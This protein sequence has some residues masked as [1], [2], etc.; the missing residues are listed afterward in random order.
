MML[1]D[2]VLQNRSYRGF[3]ESRK[4][5]ME[6][7]LDMIDHARLTPS[8]RNAQPLCYYAANETDEVA[9]IQAQTKWAGALPELHLPFE[10]TKPTAFIVV[11]INKTIS[12]QIQAFQKDVGIAAQ[13]ILLRAAEMGLGGC[14]IGSFAAGKLSEELELP[15]DILPQLVIALGK[16]METVKIVE[17][18]EGDSVK[19]Y[20]DEANVHYVPKRK[21]EDIVITKR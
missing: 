21:L 13:T 4:I 5:T 8:S 17:V 10:G 12:D 1:K 2:L 9:K 14:M 3:D 19:Y 6:E 11:C 15:E 16:P 20:R 18:E 7:L